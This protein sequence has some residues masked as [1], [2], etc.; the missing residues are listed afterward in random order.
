MQREAGIED[1]RKHPQNVHNA[2]QDSHKKP[3]TFI[4]KR[5]IT[6]IFLFY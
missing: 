3:E 4:I 2:L 1:F 6:F 5:L